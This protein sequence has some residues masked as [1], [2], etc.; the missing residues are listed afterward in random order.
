MFRHKI[1]SLV[2]VQVT[3]IQAILRLTHVFTVVRN[4]G[5][6]VTV[7]LFAMYRRFVLRRTVFVGVT[8]SCGKTTT[9]E[10]I[11]AV[12]AS[13]FTGQ[14]NHGTRNSTGEV[15]RNLLRVRGSDSYCIQELS[16]G[17]YCGRFTLESP[18]KI[19][20]PNIGVVTNIGTDHLHLFGSKQAIA[21]EKSK[22]VRS[23]PR[24]GSAILN[25]DDPL[26]FEM[27]D[28][29]IGRVI[30]YGAGPNAMVRGV[31][32]SS[33]WPERLSFTVQFKD[34]SFLV[35][36]QL[37]GVH[38]MH[39]VLAALAVGLS[40][41]VSLEVAVQAVQAVPPFPGRM[42][43]EELP[44]GV[45]FIRD[46]W[47]APLWSFP[48]ALEFLGQAKATRK[49]VIVGTISDYLGESKPKY[50]QI[51]KQAGAISDY[52]FFVGR[53]APR[54]L[55][56][57][58]DRN[59]NSLKAFA[60]VG[61]LGE[62]LR[63]FLQ[64]GDLVLV[65]GSPVDHLQ[66]LISLLKSNESDEVRNSAKSGVLPVCF[67]D[68]KTDSP[69]QSANA[70]GPPSLA[71]REPRTRCQVIVGLGNGEAHYSSTRHNVGQR[72]VDTIAKESV[73]H[74]E[75]EDCAMVA[76]T[77]VVGQSV[78]LVKLL[79]SMNTSG[80]ALKNLG[81]RLGF[82]AADCVLVYDDM[83]LPVGKVR[84]RMRGSAGGH[85]GVLSIITAYQCEEFRR[86]KI[87]IGKPPDRK[88][89]T[90][91]VLSSFSAVEEI[92]IADAVAEACSRV[93][94]LVAPSGPSTVVGHATC[95]PG[96]SAIC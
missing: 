96:S 27:A 80:P 95:N 37:C 12:L 14:K 4:S 93:L 18:L 73:A 56:A 8:G 41:G 28:Q 76:R 5:L 55:P 85:K 47:K 33:A 67:G 16:I 62:Y 79:T 30:T 74:W 64:P 39:S 26:A 15:L 77:R 83:D 21:A 75:R 9:K 2:K 89:D 3:R 69:T 94:R 63:T 58:K 61:R 84:E 32:F 17:K 19:L 10:L 38:W 68:T 78:Y 81:E 52:V 7:W 71:G 90:S 51:A 86:V 13:Q 66:S 34:Q 49:L 35:Q 59:D 43:P 82:S 53:W 31:N 22:L 46:D 36:T 1:Y 25:A 72:V 23:L 11:D 44:S 92:R 29:C 54:C 24:D 87:G 70:V 40:L 57:K 20:R 65:K 60:T 6:D 45:T 48:P 50:V 91:F 88:L 42:S